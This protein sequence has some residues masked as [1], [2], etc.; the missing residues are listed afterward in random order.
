MNRGSRVLKN[1]GAP[2]VTNFTYK[3]RSGGEGIWGCGGDPPFKNIIIH[4]ARLERRQR[5]TF[6]MD[7]SVP[8]TSVGDA[9]SCHH[10]KEF[11]SSVVLYVTNC[12]FALRTFLRIYSAESI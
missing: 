3:K 12:T 7:T 10:A 8:D 1:L 6:V 2:L 4:N 5:Y 11:N 9:S